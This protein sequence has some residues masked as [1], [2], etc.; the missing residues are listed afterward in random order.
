MK[1]IR[2]RHGMSRTR[3]FSVW[4]DIQTRCHNKN[5]IGYEGYGGRGIRVCDE[6]RASFERFL[7]DMGP[8]PSDRHSIERIDN[9][10][11]YEPGNCR[12]ATREEQANNKRSNTRIEIDGR[13]QTL[14]QWAKEI[15]ITSSALLLR[16]RSGRSGSDL[17]APNRHKGCVTH[18]GITDTYDGWSKR[19]GIKPSTIAM[20]LTK[21]GWSVADALTKGASL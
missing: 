12:W 5:F 21:Y 3:E 4:T 10:R 17:I 13:T 16:I 7:E 20:R 15:G 11:D 9:D 8:R 1:R 2:P 18:A 19:T 6:W 14:A